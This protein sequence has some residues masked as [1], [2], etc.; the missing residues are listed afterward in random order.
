MLPDWKP[1]LDRFSHEILKD[2]KARARLP[3]EAV[4]SGWLGFPPASDEE[5]KAL[6]D[7]LA[8]HLPHSC[9]S[10]LV[11]TD[12]WRTAGAFIYDLLP[13]SRPCWFRERHQDWIDAWNEGAATVGEPLPVSDEEY[14]VCGPEQDC[15][16]FRDEYWQASLAI[17]GVGD[18]AICLL[19]P[20]VRTAEGEWEAWFFANWYPGAARCRS[21]REMMEAALATFV[22]LRDNP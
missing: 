1:F 5:I 19:D 12:G 20:L 6:E 11:T 13:A 9:R 15:C 3:A 8:T 14:F 18:S 22:R 21:F 2:E 16:K 17:S 4:E 7:R 10:F